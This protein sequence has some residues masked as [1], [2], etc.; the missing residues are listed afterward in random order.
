MILDAVLGIAV[1]LSFILGAFLYLI[2]KEEVDIIL[3]KFSNPT[4]SKLKEVAL[5]PIGLL[6]IVLALA[7]IS[8]Y[9]E[10]AGLLI[11]ITGVSAGS[12][13]LAHDKKRKVLFYSVECTLTFMVFFFLFF[14]LLQLK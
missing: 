13:I 5:V 7:T 12:F 10:L 3:K 9:K 14:I 2:T 4:L 6:G 1:S 8:D 11:F